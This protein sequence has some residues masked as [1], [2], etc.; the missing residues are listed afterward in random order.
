MRLGYVFVR[1]VVAQASAQ[2][3]VCVPRRRAASAGGRPGDG[4]FLLRAT[5]SID[6]AWLL[7]G[8]SSKP[9]SHARERDAEEAAKGE[10]Q[11]RCSPDTG[12]A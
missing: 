9:E 5:A 3:G 11:Q 2:G 10:G 12:E 8:V 1:V 6:L 4:K 7:R